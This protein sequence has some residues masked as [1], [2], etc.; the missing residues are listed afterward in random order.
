VNKEYAVRYSINGQ[1]FVIGKVISVRGE[2][3][4]YFRLKSHRDILQKLDAISLA[5]ELIDHLELEEERE[6][7]RA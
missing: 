3:I 5:P 6:N 4:F 2:R 7:P 1:S